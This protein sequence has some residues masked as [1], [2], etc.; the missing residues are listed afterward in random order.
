TIEVGP[1]L[2]ASHEKGA[3][4]YDAIAMRLI[5]YDAV[6]LGSQ[7]FGLG[8]D[9]L[10]EFLCG[11]VLPGGGSDFSGCDLTGRSAF[12]F[13]A[14]NLGFE[15]EPALQEFVDNGGIAGS[16]IVHKGGELIG[17]VGVTTPLLPVVATPRD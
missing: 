2:E 3:P 10:A 13:L 7:E 15:H 1:I 5:G 6:A 14:V 16:T 12:P 9:V 17:I 11:I 4:Y 8:P